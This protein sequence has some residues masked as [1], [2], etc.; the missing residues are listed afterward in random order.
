MK[1]TK[2]SINVPRF[3]R[4]VNDT[5]DKS[6]CIFETGILQLL[7]CVT[8]ILALASEIVGLHKITIL[9]NVVKAVVVLVIIVYLVLTISI[10]GVVVQGDFG[11]FRDDTKAS[12][13]Q[14]SSKIEFCTHMR[15]R[16]YAT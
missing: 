10:G 2:K 3:N 11:H 1:Y 4:Q 15:R 5:I 16:T 13:S 9:Y 7:N 14:H 8:T 6:C 12:P